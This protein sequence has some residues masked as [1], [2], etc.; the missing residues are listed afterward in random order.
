MRVSESVF[1]SR[2]VKKILS[3]NNEVKEQDFRYSKTDWGYY[4]EYRPL[5][6]NE[7]PADFIVFMDLVGCMSVHGNLQAMVPTIEHYESLGDF[8]QK[9][10]K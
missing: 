1:K 4:L 9:L 5:F 3:L 7:S 10:G 6:P 8:E 2:V